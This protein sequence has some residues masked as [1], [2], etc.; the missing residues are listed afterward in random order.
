MGLLRLVHAFTTDWERLLHSEPDQRTRLRLVGTS[1]WLFAKSSL[2]R[3]RRGCVEHSLLG[4][5]VAG[6]NT[7]ILKF[8]FREI[9]VHGDYDFR[10]SREDPLILDC[11]ANI[12][13]ATLYFTWR[14]PKA[15]VHAFEP[16]PETFAFLRR[17]IEANGLKNA[18][19]HC[20]AVSDRN[21][22]IAF[23]RDE[24]KPGYPV[25]STV[26]VRMPKDETAVDCIMLSS[27]LDK[28]LPGREVDL[29][30]LDI[31]GAEQ[32]VLR[33]LAGSGALA[34]V[35]ELIIEYHHHMGADPSRLGRF[36]GVLEEEGFSY[37]LHAKAVPLA[38]RDRFQ[39]VLLYC[40][41]RNGL[42]GSTPD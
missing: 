19:A 18:H 39:D 7:P 6:F 14:Y 4:L 5:R 40:Y 20:L 12:G 9:F 32:A 31:E 36:L 3:G 25:M 42:A 10:A 26:R 33:N 15:E 13:M 17:N 27:F 22:R 37:Q 41:R 35:R 23:Y 11:G 2:T 29:L 28:E 34:R 24:S 30:K 38:V 21:G 1:L 16:D 8:L